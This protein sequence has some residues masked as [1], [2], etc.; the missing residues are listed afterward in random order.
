MTCPLLALAAL[1]ASAAFAAPLCDPSTGAV[2]RADYGFRHLTVRSEALGLR[3]REVLRYDLIDPVRRGAAPSGGAGAREPRE[4]AHV[5]W[6]STWLPFGQRT[7]EREAEAT[8]SGQVLGAIHE[9][10]RQLQV[11]LGGEPGDYVVVESIELPG[12]GQ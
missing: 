3:P 9:P 12:D 5:G 10:V 6:N 7:R 4:P 8:L 2:L 1:S 11:A